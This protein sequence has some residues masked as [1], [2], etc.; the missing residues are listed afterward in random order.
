MTLLETESD[1]KNKP[2]TFSMIKEWLSKAEAISEYICG[3]TFT[4]ELA[5]QM[6]Q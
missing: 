1:D 4:V 5:W 3:C 6:E 2:A